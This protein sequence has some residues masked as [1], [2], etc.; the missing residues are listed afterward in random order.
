[1]ILFFKKGK[2]CKI[3]A[4]CI[5]DSGMP[6]AFNK[7]S[8]GQKR[9]KTNSKKIGINHGDIY[10]ALLIESEMGSFNRLFDAWQEGGYVDFVLF[11]RDTVE[12]RISQVNEFIETI[13]RM[14]LK[15]EKLGTGGGGNVINYV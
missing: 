11:D 1:M 5:D 9:L 10:V 7:L 13:S 6:P 3:T 14:A 2:K 4:L 8:I 15:S 12:P